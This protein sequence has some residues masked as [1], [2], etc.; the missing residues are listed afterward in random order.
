MS[1]SDVKSWMCENCKTSKNPSIKENSFLSENSN[2]ISDLEGIKSKLQVHETLD[3]SD[4]EI[5]LT[6]AAEAGNALLHEN[7]KLVQEVQDLPNLASME[8]KVEDLLANEEQYLN[9]IEA[10]QGKLQ[11]TLLQLEKSKQQQVELQQIFE[12]HDQAQG[13]L[14]RQYLNKISNLEKEMSRLSNEAHHNLHDIADETKKQK[15][16]KSTE[17]QT[18]DGT[19]CTLTN[20]PIVLEL[21]RLCRRQDEVELKIDGLSAQLNNLNLEPNKDTIT[22]FSNLA[23]YNQKHKPKRH[24]MNTSYRKPKNSG[25]GD[26][27]FSVSLQVAKSKSSITS[28]DSSQSTT[29]QASILME[30]VSQ[31][32]TKKLSTISLTEDPSQS[33]TPQASVLTEGVSQ[34]LA[35]KLSTISLTEDP[36][37]STTPQAT[38]LTEG[39]SQTLTKKLS[40]ISSTKDPS[41]LTT[42]QASVLTEGVSQTLTKKLSTTSLT[43]EPSQSTTPQAS[44]LTEGVS[45][46]LTKKLSTTSLTEEPSQSTTPQATPTAFAPGSFHTKSTNGLNLDLSDLYDFLFMCSNHKK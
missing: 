29:P 40:T 32:L 6:L 35:K 12:D 10:L 19:F 11:E 33:T 36:S 31:T 16:F 39:V 27:V 4:L 13:Q 42:P 18:Y 24:N 38:V 34:T 30:G 20:T 17:T 14:L 22:S 7:T 9:R 45:Q 8:A 43:E 26:N 44:V 15:C 46:T 25:K 23:N 37:Q 1:R 21:A 3:E 28:G 2:K 5:S 41:Q